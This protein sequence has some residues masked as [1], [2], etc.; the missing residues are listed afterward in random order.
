MSENRKV[1]FPVG[2]SRP[3]VCHDALDI[4]MHRGYRERVRRPLPGG[5]SLEK[6]RGEAIA[7]ARGLEFEDEVG[8]RRADVESR[9][10]AVDAAQADLADRRPAT[11]GKR[12]LSP[13]I[14]DRHEIRIAVRPPPSACRRPF[15]GLRPLRSGSSRP[16]GP[17]GA[18]HTGAA[19]S[20]CP[21][22]AR[23]GSP[24]I[25]AG[26]RWPGRSRAAPAAGSV[27]TARSG[28]APAG[29][30]RSRTPRKPGDPAGFEP[31]PS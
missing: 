11:D 24:D 27:G 31:S 23:D 16:I 6:R 17:R 2:R 26:C 9:P 22:V 14:D 30:R 5:L 4:D 7:R 21:A 28:A 1:T 3:D 15:H 19:R 10:A 20:A 25:P 18:R 8:S 13:C 29:H 12:A